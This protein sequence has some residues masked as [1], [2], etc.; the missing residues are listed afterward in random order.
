M[1]VC[2][3]GYDQVKVVSTMG[4]YSTYTDTISSMARPFLCYQL[5]HPSLQC[6]LRQA[7]AV[8]LW[9]PDLSLLRRSAK[10]YRRRSV[11]KREE[12]IRPAKYTETNEKKNKAD[13]LSVI[14]EGWHKTEKVDTG[15]SSGCLS[16]SLS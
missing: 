8:P 2:T 9:Q 14:I 11:Y 15:T 12:K 16:L 1:Y 3:K 5:P 7:E 4:L 13:I 6:L 10:T